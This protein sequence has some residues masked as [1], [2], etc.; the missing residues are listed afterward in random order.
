MISLPICLVSLSPNLPHQNFLSILSNI[1]ISPLLTARVIQWITTPT[2]S[3]HLLGHTWDFMLILPPSS[4]TLPHTLTSLVSQT[5]YIRILVPP[6]FIQTFP[7]RNRDLLQQGAA[8]DIGVAGSQNQITNLDKPLIASSS[9]RVELTPA[10]LAFARSE[11][12]PKGPVTMLNLLS[13]HPFR[14]PRESYERFVEG[15]KDGVAG[16]VKVQGETEGLGEWDEVV[17]T[18]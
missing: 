14:Q 2:S 12:C 8:S 4:P 6:S 18:Q 3:P 9:Q 13:F 15:W 1:S 10:L 11:L 17:L 7:A 16:E 5:F